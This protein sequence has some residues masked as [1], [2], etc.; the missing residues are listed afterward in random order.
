MKLELDDLTKEFG[1]F[2]AVNHIKLT[3][4]NGVYGLLGV[5]G[6]GK[7][8]LMRMNSTGVIEPLKYTCG[9]NK[10]WQEYTFTLIMNKYR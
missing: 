8:T 7:T 3:M 4:T 5:N 2:T 6:A 9:T 1:G 10:T